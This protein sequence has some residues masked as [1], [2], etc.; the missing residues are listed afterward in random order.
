M[1]TRR[2]VLLQIRIRC[3]S[4]GGGGVV[5][6]NVTSKELGKLFGTLH[7]FGARDDRSCL[8]VGAVM[9]TVSSI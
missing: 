6:G 8:N 4:E 5:V 7:R 9:K 2:S 3:N 1:S